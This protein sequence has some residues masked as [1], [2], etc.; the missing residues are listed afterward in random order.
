MTFKRLAIM[1]DVSRGHYFPYYSIFQYIG[2]ADNGDY[3]K[4][5][6]PNI[7][8]PIYVKIYEENGN[9]YD[10]VIDHYLNVYWNEE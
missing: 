8:E 2:T 4:F 6:H 7:H 1:Q 10:Y 9:L 3:W 5:K